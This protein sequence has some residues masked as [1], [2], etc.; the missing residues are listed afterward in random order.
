MNSPIRAVVFSDV[1]HTLVDLQ[2]PNEATPALDVLASEGIA[3]VFCSSHT[4][5]EIESVRQVLGVRHPFICENGAALFVPQQYFGSHTAY[6]RDVAG[7]HAV[8]FGRPYTEV[9]DTLRR[10]AARLRLDIVGFND[11]SVEEVAA[12]C[13]LSLLQARLAKLREYDEP[14]RL[15]DPQA[16]AHRRLS[17]A[18]D[19]A[20]LSSTH[21]G[22]FDHVGAA[23]DIGVAAR[24]VT[25]LYQAARTPVTTVAFGDPVADVAL[26]R[27]VDVPVAI[28]RYGA[29]ALSQRRSRVAARFS[30]ATSV[31]EWVEGIVHIVRDVGSAISYRPSAIER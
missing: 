31:G 1:H 20:R 28:E 24:L 25:Q 6:A 12:E 22:R 15:V 21:R 3:L 8:E 5:A 11:M 27:G 26:L 10:T 23:V 13:H 29:A 4:R 14:F 7:Y 16:D 18:L 30:N 2:T 9:V 19:G 17:K